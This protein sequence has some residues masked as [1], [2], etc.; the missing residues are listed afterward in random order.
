MIEFKPLQKSEV[1]KW[2]EIEH[3]LYTYNDFTFG[4][5]LD[6]FNGHQLFYC[7]QDKVYYNL[8]DDIYKAIEEFNDLIGVKSK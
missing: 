7:K 5:E 1:L 8:G 6:L 2:C 4:I 3:D